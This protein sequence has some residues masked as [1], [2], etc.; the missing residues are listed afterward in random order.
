[1]VLRNYF[2]CTIKQKHSKVALRIQYF[3]CIILFMLTFN[4]CEVLCLG[5]IQIIRDTLGGRGGGLAKMSHDNFY[6]QFH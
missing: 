1:M 5:A 4:N 2:L 6:W 3:N